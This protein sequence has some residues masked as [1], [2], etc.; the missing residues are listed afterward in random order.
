MAPDSNGTGRR[1][2]Q[3]RAYLRLLARL[4]L[5]PGLQS[6]LDPS[7][8]VQQTLL[9][10]HQ[11]LRDCERRND[12]ELAGWLR[13]ALV[14]NLSHVVRDFGRARRDVARERSLDAAIDASSAHLD[15]WLA[16]SD[17]TSPSAEAEFHEDALRLAEA[18]E[19]LP[20]A[21][22][23][24]LIYHHWQGWSLAEIAAEMNRSPAAVAGLLKRGLQHL[25]SLLRNENDRP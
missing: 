3:F 11:A 12:A 7:D 2:E 18:L 1:L 5:H 10:A 22:R 17:Q 19:Q 15:R 4:N 9:Q 13:Q 23:Q 16:D 6:K 21:Q 20:E 25:R 14:R 24:A 8:V